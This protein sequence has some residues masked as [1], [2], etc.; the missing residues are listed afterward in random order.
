MA[1]VVTGKH[2]GD[3]ERLPKW[4]QDHIERLQRRAD[5]AEEDLAN[6]LAAGNFRRGEYNTV[7]VPKGPVL[8]ASER[9]ASWG[10]IQVLFDS[11]DQ[12]EITSSGRLAIEPSASNV[13]TVRV[14]P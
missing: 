14:R 8:H 5:R 1:T 7:R 6:H 3:T 11:D 2:V 12:V 10:T 4:A 9:S 13:V